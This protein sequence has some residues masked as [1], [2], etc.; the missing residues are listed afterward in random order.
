[1]S[2]EFQQGVCAVCGGS[3]TATTISHEERRGDRFFLFQNVPAQVCERCG[4][5]WIEEKVL[6]EID[7]LIERGLPTRIEEMAVFDLAQ[8]PTG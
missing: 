5:V 1:M 8:V 3:L 7:R 4:E 6:Q 2:T